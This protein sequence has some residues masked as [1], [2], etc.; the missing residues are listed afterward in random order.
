[1][2]L[3]L[4]VDRA[5][6]TAHVQATAHAYGHGLVPVVKGNGYGFGRHALHQ[7]VQSTGAQFVCVGDVHELH[8]VPSALTPVV[9]TPTL[10]APT[11][12]RPILTVGDVAHVRALHGWHGSVMVKLRSSMR[13]HGASPEQLPMLLDAVRAA[14]LQVAAFALHLPLAGTD[15]DRLAEVTAWVPHLHLGTAIWVS[16]LAPD[17]VRTL[18][19]AHPDREW[20][21]RVGTALWHGVPKGPFLHLSA[22]VLSA[23]SVRAGEPAG[24]RATPVPFDGTLLSIGVGS[25]AGVAP[26]EHADPANRSPFHFERTRLALLESPHMHTSLVVVPQG[27][28]CPTI[29]D[30]VD[31]QRPLTTTW[32]DEIV[33]R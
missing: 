11:S 29:G 25:A 20:S 28:P 3:R 31:V 22:N 6:W 24:Y 13:R 33:W 14:G 27:E 2:T 12:T 21:V 5:A 30:R 15:A 1:M 8:D 26:L 7:A 4:T 10:A 16:H 17:T 18:R 32:V 23:Q 9:L 19:A